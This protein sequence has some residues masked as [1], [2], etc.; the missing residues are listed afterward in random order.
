MNEYNTVVKDNKLQIK[1]LMKNRQEIKVG[2]AELRVETND[3]NN[4]IKKVQKV[5]QKLI[6]QI[7]NE[8]EQGNKKMDEVDKYRE[9]I[10]MVNEKT[11]SKH[12][13]YKQNKSTLKHRV[14]ELNDNILDLQT[15]IG[16]LHQ[17]IHDTKDLGIFR[18]IYF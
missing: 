14:K 9:L 16:D 17:E 13:G 18:N 3:T 2:I 5:N 10:S 12:Q 1:D 8:I 11:N 4:D 6:S 7:D 15:D